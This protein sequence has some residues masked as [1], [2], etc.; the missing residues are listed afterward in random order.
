MQWL[1]RFKANS[2]N[3][4]IY[5]ILFFIISNGILDYYNRTVLEQH[6]AV[7]SE[8]TSVQLTMQEV[9]RN[10]NNCDMGFR[11]YYIIPTEQLLIPY[12]DARDSLPVFFKR[13]KTIVHKQGMNPSDIQPVEKAFYGYFDLVEQMVEWRKQENFRAI[14][15]V[16]RADPG[17]A[18]WFTY[19]DYKDALEIKEAAILKA[20]QEKT[21]KI[22]FISTAVRIL[23]FALGIPTL[24]IV[25]IKLTRDKKRRVQ[26]FKALDENNQRYLFRPHKNTQE[27]E[28]LDENKL[29]ETLIENLR[30]AT[31]F[32]SNIA[33][34][35]FDISWDGLHEENKELNR[36][37][38]AGELLQMK[39]QMIK[40]KQEDQIR[41]WATEGVS[42]FAELVRQHQDDVDLLSDKITATV[43]KYLGANQASLFFVEDNGEGEIVLK[44]YGCYAYDRKKHMQK[45]LAP[46][47]GMVGQTY[48]EKDVTLLTAIPKNYVHITSGLGEAT[49][50][51]LAIIPL[52]FNETVEGVLEIASFKVFRQHEIEFLQKIGEIIA[53]AILTLR[54]ST[55][56]KRLME[57]LQAQSEEMKAQEEEMRQNMEEL[58]ATQEEM[59]RKAREYQ[60]I[61]VL[62]ETELARQVEENRELQKLLNNT[63]A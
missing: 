26:L 18:V 9:I 20:S 52:K 41:L 38:L 46:G 5:F 56:M 3:Y 35:N 25:V 59:S 1:Q 11:G 57:N 60:D 15:S 7:S 14:D 45:T 44:L 53:S 27:E 24:L 29:I 55:E 8:V 4:S 19:K 62:R 17:R 32:I 50:T 43:V 40:V 48:L 49:P 58:Q 33:K 21:N 63:K 2:I 13:L 28:Q 42:K 51:C 47:E 61:I 36:E 10:L 16:I 23:L 39:E 22:M 31:G 37:N 6:E 12:T 34:G 54:S 30:K